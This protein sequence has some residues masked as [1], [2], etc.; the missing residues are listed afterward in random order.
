MLQEKVGE[1]AGVVWNILNGT[2]GMTLKDI[3][4]EA[5]KNDVKLLDKDVYLAL[6]WLL[7]ENKVEVCEEGKE[8][9]VKLI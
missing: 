5:K 9:F 6:G 2:E 3:K 1:T 7:R 8:L 4:S